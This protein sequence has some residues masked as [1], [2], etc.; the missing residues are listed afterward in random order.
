MLF[1]NALH[2][3]FIEVAHRQPKNGSKLVLAQDLEHSDKQSVAVEDRKDEDHD[4]E[5]V[6]IVVHEQIDEEGN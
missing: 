2:E 4:F 6:G 3:L 5:G 1:D